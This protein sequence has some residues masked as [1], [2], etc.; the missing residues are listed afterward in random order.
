MSTEIKYKGDIIA[1]ITRGQI[2]TLTCK[3]KMM[4][5]DIIVDCETGVY[6]GSDM[7]PD[8]V[9][10]WID[11]N[12]KPTSVENWE[13]DFD[14]ET[15]TTKK[16]VVLDSDDAEEGDKAAILRLRQADGTWIEIPALVGGQG[17]Q[18]ERGDS[19]VYIGTDTPPETANVWI[20][21]NGVPTGT[22]DW[23]F[24]LEDDSTETK[25]VVVI[26]ADE[27]SGQLAMLKMRQEDGSWVEI[28][29]IVGSQGKDGD[30]VT[31]VRVTESDE[32]GGENVVEFSDGKSVR[33]KNGKAKLVDVLSDADKDEIAA[34][35][36]E[37][38]KSDTWTLTYEDGSTE[39]VEVYIK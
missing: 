25:K 33:I 14:D 15:S 10:V 2:A 6:I 31:V 3:N 32:D 26:G 8:S 18:G 36:R 39:T 19:G 24:D 12:G 13:V 29:A 9:N 17:P 28:P 4:H 23:E 34:K 16:V 11:P 1:T 20:N 35:V 5:G 30:S 37:S 7:P 21:P 22:E 38:M 27:A